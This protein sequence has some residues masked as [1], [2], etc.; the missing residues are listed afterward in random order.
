MVG[1]GKGAE[2]GI[3]I[4]KSESL[5]RAGEITTVVLDKTGTLTRGQPA[6]THIQLMDFAKGQDE[7]IRLTASIEKASE[8]PW[9]KPLRRMLKPG[10]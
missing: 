2:M 8:H 7:L 10:G 4:K 3:L 9:V 6:V 5:E 1:T